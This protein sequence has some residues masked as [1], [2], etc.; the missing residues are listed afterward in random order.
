MTGSYFGALV[1]PNRSDPSSTP[2]EVAALESEIGRK[3]DIVNHFYLYDQPLGT[4]GEVQDIAGG[5]I[6]MVTWGATD[7][8]AIN[9][10]SQDSYITAQAVRLKNL[11]APVFL[12]YYHE[13]DGDYRQAMVHSPA[14]YI[15]AWRH[16]RDLFLQAGA[17]NVVWVFC[18]TT[19]TFRTVP[20]TPPWAYYPGDAYV[21]WVAG[22][23]YS[24]A[25]V[26][27][28][29]KWNSFATIFGKW[30]DWA[31]TRPKPMMVAEYGVLEDPATPGRKAAWYNAMASTVKTTMPL[32][33]AVVAWST[34]NTKSG[35]VYNWNVDSS[36]S[37]LNAWKAMA[38]DSYFNPTGK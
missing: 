35:L 28:G 13:P 37:S 22:D 31:A 15:A 4:Q 12:R 29:A 32:I 10:G 11:G 3:L 5:R 26:K 36:T 20:A 33:Q 23:G 6:P 8:V 17:T 34:T 18:T 2:T 30:Y 7:T 21:N 38:T 9:N 24:F 1:N 27:P 16:A 19:Y 25:P 14:Q